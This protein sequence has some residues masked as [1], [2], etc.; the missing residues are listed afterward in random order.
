MKAKRFPKQLLSV[1]VRGEVDNGRREWKNGAVSVLPSPKS[2]W[3]TV[4]ISCHMGS[5]KAA[6][7]T[8]GRGPS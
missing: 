7:L 4:P 2:L 1:R 8:G 6:T 3:D 5:P